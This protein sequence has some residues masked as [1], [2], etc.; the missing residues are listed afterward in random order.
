MFLLDG[1]ILTH[2]CAHGFEIRNSKHVAGYL[3]LIM[4]CGCQTRVLCVLHKYLPKQSGHQFK[5]LCRVCKW[6]YALAW[7]VCDEWRVEFAARDWDRSSAIRSTCANFCV[8]WW[9][10]EVGVLLDV[11]CTRWPNHVCTLCADVACEVTARAVMGRANMTM[12]IS[13]SWSRLGGLDRGYANSAA[14]A[15]NALMRSWINLV[16]RWLSEVKMDDAW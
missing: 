9:R 5:L 10:V 6:K 1:S 11:N 3:P 16:S 8:W 15:S 4:Q 2:C 14:V 7:N 12:Y 13:I